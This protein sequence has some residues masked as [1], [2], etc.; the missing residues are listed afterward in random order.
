MPSGTK[1]RR[2]K[3]ETQTNQN[4]QQG[5]GVAFISPMEKKSKEKVKQ[6][7][8]TRVVHTHISARVFIINIKQ[9]RSGEKKRV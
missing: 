8:A 1:P 4:K 2:G 9:L 6:R 3:R 7:T 5:F